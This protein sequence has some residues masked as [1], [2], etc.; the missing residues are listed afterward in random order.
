[1][2]GNLIFIAANKH[3]IVIGRFFVEQFRVRKRVNDIPVN[4]AL[5]HEVSINPVHI[6]IG[7]WQ[8]E[9]LLFLFFSCFC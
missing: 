5:F 8:G 9:R 1:M 2:A 7:G 3:A 4:P 6:R